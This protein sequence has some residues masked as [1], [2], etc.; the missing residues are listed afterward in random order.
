MFGSVASRAEAVEAA[1]E[2]SRVRGVLDV[3][4]RLEVRP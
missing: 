1:D 3:R 2:A 4:N